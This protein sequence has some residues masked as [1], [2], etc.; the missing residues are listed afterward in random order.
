MLSCGGPKGG[1]KIPTLN[2]YKDRRGASRKFLRNSQGG[3]PQKRETADCTSKLSEWICQKVTKSHL[4]MC[5]IGTEL[6]GEM[7]RFLYL[8]ASMSSTISLY[9]RTILRQYLENSDKM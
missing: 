7:L 2:L 1:V 9:N 4:D 5:M 3:I 8:A 6:K